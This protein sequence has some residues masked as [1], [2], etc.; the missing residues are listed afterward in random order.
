VFEADLLTT[1][2]LIG[3]AASRGDLAKV[4][5]RL[6]TERG[7][8][9]K[10]LPRADILEMV[11]DEFIHHR[12]HADRMMHGGD[13]FKAAK[14]IKGVHMK[15]DL[16]ECD[17]VVDGSRE[18]DKKPHR[19][20]S[21]IK[22]CNYGKIRET[23]NLT[24]LERARLLLGDNLLVDCDCNA[25]RYFY[26]YN[27]TKRGFALVA[28]KRRAKK[29]NPGNS[30]SVC[31]H[32]E[33]ALKYL[34]ANYS[35]IAS[36]MKR[37]QQNLEESMTTEHGI[38]EALVCGHL[39]EDVNKFGVTD[40]LTGLMAECSKR[41]MAKTASAIRMALTMAATEGASAPTRPTLPDDRTVPAPA[42][43]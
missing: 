41:G 30:G 40:T 42:N 35:V 36:A 12:D 4:L 9:K 24:W 22:F 34:G 38:S 29:T 33:H 1:L 27:A 26:R 32:L 21:S 23:P 13:G 14:G 15:A 20:V 11:D 2:P 39:H 5:A 28:E 18:W 3:E 6:R 37:H 31:K 10:G 19:Y 43:P 17:I 7:W 8:S 16:E 25:Y